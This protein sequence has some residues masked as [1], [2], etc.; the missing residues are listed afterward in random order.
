MMIWII[1]NVINAV[2]SFNIDAINAFNV[3][4]R[5]T[6]SSD[7]TLRSDMDHCNLGKEERYSC[8]IGNSMLS[9]DG[10]FY[11]M[12]V[13]NANND[14][15]VILSFADFAYVEFAINLHESFKALQL[16]Q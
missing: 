8:L 7:T 1:M 16:L 6:L 9:K 12:L 5:K 14:K 3:I 13:S 4:S 10:E 11:K 15:L 2:N